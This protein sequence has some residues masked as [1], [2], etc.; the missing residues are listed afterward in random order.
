[1]N[2]TVQKERLSPDTA[3]ALHEFQVARSKLASQEARQAGLSFQ[4]GPRDVFITTTPKSGTT[5]MTQICHQLRTGGDMDFREIT[6]VV[7]FLECAADLGQNCDDKQR[8]EP[9]LYKTHF[10]EASCPKGGKYITVVRHP[11]DVVVSQCRFHAAW[12]FRAEDIETNLYVQ[13]VSLGGSVPLQLTQ[14][15]SQRATAFEH[16]MGL[17]A[18]T[19]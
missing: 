1:M 13:Q 9:R 18:S 8:A 17:V 16:Y 14:G 4:P 5:W 6:E 12:M 15:Y 7:P 2:G 19:T 10:T 3:A 11:Y